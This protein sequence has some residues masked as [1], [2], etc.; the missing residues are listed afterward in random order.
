MAMKLNDVDEDAVRPHAEQTAR[1]PRRTQA[2]G[3]AAT[4]TTVAD[5]AID[6]LIEQGVGRG[7]R[8]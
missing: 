5:A 4:R 7:L 1:H 3:G 6:L 2:N 8:W